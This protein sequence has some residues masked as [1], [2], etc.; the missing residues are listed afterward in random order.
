MSIPGSF[1][2]EFEIVVL[3]KI[4]I[5]NQYYIEKYLYGKAILLDCNSFIFLVMWEW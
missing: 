1:V 2:S 4:H 5:L 3:T